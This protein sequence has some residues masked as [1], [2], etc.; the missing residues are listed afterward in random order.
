MYIFKK[1]VRIIQSGN[2]TFNTLIIRNYKKK[3]LDRI[4]FYVILLDFIIIIYWKTYQQIYMSNF[5]VKKAVDQPGS[6]S[7]DNPNRN[8]TYTRWN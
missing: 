7:L 8:K 3:L 2:I 1:Y 6:T 4:N 5:K